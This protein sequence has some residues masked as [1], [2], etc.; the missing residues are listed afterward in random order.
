[1]VADAETATTCQCLKTAE[2]DLLPK[3][4]DV[5][6][7]PPEYDEATMKANENCNP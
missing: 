2:G 1:M 7:T 3:Y 6:E 4:E 5:A